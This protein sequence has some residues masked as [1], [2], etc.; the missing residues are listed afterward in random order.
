[1]KRPTTFWTCMLAAALCL[2][3]GCASRQPSGNN[4]TKLVIGGQT[5]DA[6]VP[7]AER[8]RIN[9][10]FPPG[11]RG[12][13]LIA[14]AMGGQIAHRQ[15]LAVAASD[16][17]MNWPQKPDA[18]LVGWLVTRKGGHYRVL[19]IAGGQDQPPRVVAI[20]RDAGH[21]TPRLERL[22]SPRAL[23]AGE[24]ALWNARRLA[25]TAKITPCSQSY[26]PVVI[27][28]DAA[29]R[30]QLYVYLLPLA[31]ADTMMLGGYY[32]IK[33]DVGG[34]RIQDTHGFTR[35]CLEMKRNPRAV[36]IAVTE[37]ESPVPTAPQVYAN[38]RYGLPVY[39]S[40]SK[41][42]RQWEIKKGRISPLKGQPSP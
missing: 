9:R 17:Y 8:A 16:A 41:N 1:M 21:A 12:S 26:H 27:P 5:M 10:T 30:K 37:H 13:V 20:A 2:T 42:D 40:T 3:A 18:H 36:G 6:L 25:F 4:S 19:F 22:G 23:T 24:T 35:S 31:P 38:L 7:A 34:T 15:H 29:G 14:E 33:T 28:V 39:V 32:L 11:Y